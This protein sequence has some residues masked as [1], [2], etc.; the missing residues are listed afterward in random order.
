MAFNYN[1][2]TLVG[3]L[4]KDPDAS[5]HSDQLKVTF[6]LAID[7]PYRC[8]DGGRDTDFIPIVVWGHSAEIARQFLRKGHPVLVSGRIQVR[9]YEKDGDT[10]WMTE[11]SCIEFQLLLRKSAQVNQEILLSNESIESD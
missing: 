9:S 1:Y 5:V 8:K 4:T 11:V 7:R 6:S 3:R 2:V 10:R